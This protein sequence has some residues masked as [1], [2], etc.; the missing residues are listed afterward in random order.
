[1]I[2]IHKTMLPVEQFQ[3]SDNA[4]EIDQRVDQRYIDHLGTSGEHSENR[5]EQHGLGADHIDAFF[6]G[7]DC[8]DGRI[9]AISGTRQ[10][11]IL[12][13]MRHRAFRGNMGPLQGILGISSGFPRISSE[14]GP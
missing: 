14:G 5:Y 7:C 1:M 8:R 10:A 12:A 4:D 6:L 2:A 9:I 11:V 3:N 13:G